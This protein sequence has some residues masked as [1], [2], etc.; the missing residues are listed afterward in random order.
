MVVVA[1]IG[2]LAALAVPRFQVFQAKAKQSEAKNNLSHIYTL[3]ESY[4]G[5]ND[6]YGTIAQIGFNVTA[7]AMQRYTYT[8]VGASATAFMGQANN[9]M[10][11]A[12]CTTDMWTINETK[13][14]VNNTPTCSSM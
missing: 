2:I 5:D 11:S 8:V 1:I 3:E 6:M 10:I 12:N 9:G 7:G 13:A 14:L 4:F